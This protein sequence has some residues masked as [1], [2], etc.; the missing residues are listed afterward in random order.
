MEAMEC[1][2]LLSLLR[3]TWAV[4]GQYWGVSRKEGRNY[5]SVG[6]PLELG[7]IATAMGAL[8]NKYL[9]GWKL[10]IESS[11]SQV[12]ME[13]EAQTSSRPELQ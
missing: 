11:A 12:V 4:S 10:A 6:F 2:D 1:T 3:A 9:D 7:M 8:K 5:T 13:K